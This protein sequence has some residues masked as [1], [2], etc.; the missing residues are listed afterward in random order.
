MA[1][2]LVVASPKDGYTLE[3]NVSGQ[4]A[5][6]FLMKVPFDVVEDF[7]TIAM[8]GVATS[9]C[10][11]NDLPVKDVYASVAEQ[12]RRMIAAWP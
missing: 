9:F 11:S 12:E 6:P 4:L 2:Q 8:A 7:S 3:L 5:F 1:G 10:V